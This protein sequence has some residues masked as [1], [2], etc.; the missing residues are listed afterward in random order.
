MRRTTFFGCIVVLVLV[1]GLAPPSSPGAAEGPGDLLAGDGHPVNH[2]GLQTAC[3]PTMSLSRDRRGES[4]ELS[5]RA[6]SATSRPG[7]SALGGPPISLP[8]YHKEVWGFGVMDGEGAL[9]T[10][11]PRGGC[12]GGPPIPLTLAITGKDGDLGLK[13]EGARS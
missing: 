3:R 2:T 7:G 12:L 4:G 9:R 11:A 13:T 1:L 10:D 8:R 6:R 5:E